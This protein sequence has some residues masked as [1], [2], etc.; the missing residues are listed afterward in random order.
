MSLS[1]ELFMP[2]FIQAAGEAFALE[3]NKVN[4][5]SILHQ[6]VHLDSRELII[7]ILTK[8]PESYEELGGCKLI[9]CKES[10]RDST[11]LIRAIANSCIDTALMLLDK[12]VVTDATDML[13]Q[14]NCVD[15]DGKTPLMLAIAK[16]PSHICDLFGGD[17]QSLII[18]RLLELSADVN[19][20]NL[21]G[22]TALHYAAAHRDLDL[23]ER[24]ILAGA[25]LDL[26]DKYGNMPI[27]MMLCTQEQADS[28]LASN[29][30]GVFTRE[31]IRWHD[32]AAFM[33]KFAQRNMINSSLT[34][35]PKKPVIIAGPFER[36]MQA[37]KARE[38]EKGMISQFHEQALTRALSIFHDYIPR[39]KGVTL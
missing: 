7:A 35:E 37:P 5:H 30:G 12:D 38:R 14:I 24:L 11:P 17:H 15:L 39:P 21:D 3:Y 23:M 4:L 10:T 13:Q 1:D 26:S 29:T 19:I 33:T 8:Y 31:N 9:H 22:Q 34:I 25:R 18:E 32:D 36:K 6:A 16:G 27:D 28:F 20:Q 2:F